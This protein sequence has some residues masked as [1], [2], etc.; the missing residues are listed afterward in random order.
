[1]LANDFDVDN[2]PVS[3]AGLT[4][5]AVGAAGHGSTAFTSGGVTYTSAANYYGPDSFTYTITDPTGL[6]S[7]ATVNV[8]NV[9]DA[10]VAVNDAKTIAEDSGANSIDV[11][12]ND[13][14]VDNQPVSNVGLT[15]TAVGAASH[16]NTAFTSSSVTYTPAANYY[17]PD[18]F[19]YT[20]TDPTSLTSSATVN[21]AI[22]NAN[23]APVAVNDTKTITEDSGSNSIDVLANDFD[24]DNQPVSNAVLTV[25]AV[26]AA[27]H[28]STAFMS[29]GVAY[30]PASNYYGPD[31]LTY[32]ITDPTGLQSSATVN[33]TV[34][35]ANDAPSALNDGKT[36][37][38]DSGSNSIDVLANDFDV[39]NQPVSNTGLTVT[40]VGAA[41]HGATAFTSSGVTYTPAANYY[42]PDSFTY[43]ITDPTGLTSSATA[44][45]TKACSPSTIARWRKQRGRTMR[46]AND[47]DFDNQPSQ[48]RPDRRSRAMDRSFTAGNVSYTPAPTTM[49]RQLYHDPDPT[50]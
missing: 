42:G 2:Q 17:G 32:T 5:T 18:S 7:S 25:I 33:I 38:E 41:G 11:L 35:N 48:C 20:I 8:T 3:N 34:T 47:F 9:N 45:V 1:M 37:A 21:V 24:V 40:A 36:V 28:G 22:T 27:G 10:P 30:S 29:G 49:A 44:S 31:S 23:D 46:P 6:T 43:A 14:D 16:G 15:V 19:T 13:F 50:G 26:G 4:V 39:D 12:A